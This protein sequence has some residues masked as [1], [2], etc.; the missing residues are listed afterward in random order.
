MDVEQ[1][2]LT[3]YSYYLSHYYLI[4]FICTCMFKIKSSINNN[5]C[6]EF[7]KHNSRMVNKLP[8]ITFAFPIISETVIGE[9][10][11]LLQKEKSNR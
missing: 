2:V 1:F 6:I 3:N 11:Y 9:S 8:F 4:V 5:N 10:I 7:K